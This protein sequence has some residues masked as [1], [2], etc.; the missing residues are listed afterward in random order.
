MHRARPARTRDADRLRHIGA[1]R[2]RRRRGPRRLRHRRRHL[3]LAQFLKAAAPKLVGLGVARQQHQRRFL[4][5]R[6]HQ[7]GGGVGMARAAGDHGDAR[8]AGQPSPGVGHVHRRRLMP[9][10]HQPL[11]RIDRRVE[12]RHDVV[13]GQREDRVVAGAFQRAHDDVGAAD[14]CAAHGRWF[15]VKSVTAAPPCAG[16]WRDRRAPRPNPAGDAAEAAAMHARSGCR[17]QSQASASRPGRRRARD[18]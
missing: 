15:P 11:P 3:G 9:R 12:Q 8:L 18:P 10:V 2:R 6:R 4:A 14:G 13:A 17:S 1:E 7:C 5:L 16:A